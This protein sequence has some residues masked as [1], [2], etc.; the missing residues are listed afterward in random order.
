MDFECLINHCFT[1]CALLYVVLCKQVSCLS[2]SIDFDRKSMLF[3]C[4][5]RRTAPRVV[6]RVRKHGYGNDD[7]ESLSAFISFVYS[8][9]EWDL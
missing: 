7:R 3:C 5:V 6:R 8:V 9:I 1:E 2:P 4:V